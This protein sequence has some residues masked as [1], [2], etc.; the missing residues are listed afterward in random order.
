MLEVLVNQV[1][2]LSQMVPLPVFTAVGSLIEELISP[3]PAQAIMLLGGSLAKTQYASQW[4]LVV[5][6]FTGAIGKSLGSIVYYMFADKI[7]DV[8]VPR[9]GKYIGVTHEQ[10]ELVGKKLGNGF[11]DDIVLFLL[12][13]LPIV[14]SAPVSVACGLFKIDLWTFVITAFIGSFFR[15]LFYLLIG[16]HGWEAYRYFMQSLVSYKQPFVGGLI[17]VVLA[18]LALTYR[19]WKKKQR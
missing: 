9:Y 15:N 10:L 7:E 11:K 18:L 1:F 6:A 19:A 5:M 13:L 2:A 4:M 16:Y 17:V 8:I 12:R 14:P 3:I